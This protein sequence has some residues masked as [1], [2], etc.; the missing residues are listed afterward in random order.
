MSFI[1]VELDA[2][3]R[4]PDAARAAGVTEHQLGWG[5]TRL[6]AWCWQEKTDRVTEDHLAG[7][8]GGDGARAARGLVAFGFL[9]PSEGS[10]RVRGAERYLR[11]SDAR[12]RAGKARAATGKRTGGRW[13]RSGE[14]TSTPPA[15]AGEP[16]STP[17]APDQLLHR[18]PITDHREEE[19]AAAAAKTDASRQGAPPE[20]HAL[21]LSREAVAEFQANPPQP[22]TTPPRLSSEL[23]AGAAF[24]AWVQ[25]R[26]L[27]AGL[28]T[29]KPPHP[30]K[31]SAW[32]SDAL[33]EL[34]GDEERLK[35]ACFR[36]SEDK[37][38]QQQAPPLPFRAFMSQWRD[39]V[40]RT[41]TG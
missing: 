36:F 4:V 31:L 25:Q 6:W 24:F 30:S 26:R 3:K 28:V 21:R 19:A 10:F 35:E 17:P 33:G 37:Y 16:T 27:V 40:P 12:A 11:I 5:L 1:Q 22:P 29:E 9:E 34:G 41:R 8:I 38:W 13:S 15:C 7:F 2:M 32:Y 23:T 18:S 14:S 39:Y 20:P